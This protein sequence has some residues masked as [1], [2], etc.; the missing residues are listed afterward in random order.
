MCLCFDVIIIFKDTIFTKLGVNE[1]K[2]HISQIVSRK[3]LY[4]INS[5]PNK[6]DA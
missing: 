4:F 3:K 2:K 6:P 5:L 1:K